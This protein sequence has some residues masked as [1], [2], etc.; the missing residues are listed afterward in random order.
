MFRY[1][2]EPLFAHS[3][4]FLQQCFEAPVHEAVPSFRRPAKS[5][6]CAFKAL[7]AFALPK[8]TGSTVAGLGGLEKIGSLRYPRPSNLLQGGRRIDR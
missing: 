1:L 3:A 6:L 5:C 7:Y 2:F 4:G 8:A